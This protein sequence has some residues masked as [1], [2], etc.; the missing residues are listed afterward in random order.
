[1][2]YYYRGRYVEDNGDWAS[3]ASVRK[4]TF[5][6]REVMNQEEL[7]ESFQEA[8][9]AES[10]GFSAQ[11]LMHHCLNL[12]FAIS[13]LGDGSKVLRWT[14]RGMPSKKVFQAHTAFELIRDWASSKYAEL[15][16]TGG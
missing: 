14:E 16:P 12:G 1:M 15:Y 3:D 8:E 7:E 2:G 9:L 13:T 4:Q 11:E 6:G 10:E 5:R